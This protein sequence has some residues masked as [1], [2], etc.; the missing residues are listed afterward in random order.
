MAEARGQGIIWPL[1]GIRRITLTVHIGREPGDRSGA[2]V[3]VFL[4]GAQ[5]TAMHSRVDSTIIEAAAKLLRDDPHLSNAALLQRLVTTVGPLVARQVP[6]TRVEGLVRKPALRILRAE[7]SRNRSPSKGRPSPREETPAD[8][9]PSDGRNAP[10][11]TPSDAPARS[12]S[13]SGTPNLRQN[14]SNARSPRGLSARVMAEVD[15]A[16]LEAFSL[17]TACQSRSE[18]V[19][20][21]RRLDTVRERMRRQLHSTS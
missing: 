16:L 8:A 21:F 11:R 14:G 6:V 19:D 7:L 12:P 9:P 13:D 5:E 15:D 10:R 20:G 2:V 3:S 17:G 18:V 4:Q 1:R